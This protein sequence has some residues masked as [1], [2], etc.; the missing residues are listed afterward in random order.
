M[1]KTNNGYLGPSTSSIHKFGCICDRKKLYLT[2]YFGSL[3][4]KSRKAYGDGSIIIVS[5]KN[6][7]T[8]CMLSYSMI[9]KIYN[10]FDVL[11]LVNSYIVALT[12]N[13]VNNSQLFTTCFHWQQ[14]T[15]QYM[16]QRCQAVYHHPAFVSHSCLVSQHTST[17]PNAGIQSGR[18]C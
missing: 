4:T 15:C 3:L 7:T 18:N 14:M 2:L 11:T 5:C 8:K 6:A 9:R 16:N 13:S 12:S 17:Q 1:H 10:L